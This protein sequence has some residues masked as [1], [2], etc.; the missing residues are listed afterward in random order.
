[1]T[2]HPICN[3]QVSVYFYK[4]TISYLADEPGDEQEHQYAVVV[5][6]MAKEGVGH[7]GRKEGHLSVGLS[8]FHFPQLHLNGLGTHRHIIFSNGFH[9]QTGSM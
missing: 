7:E 4:H 1:M 5:S 9:R 8:H 3:F 2:E 6:T